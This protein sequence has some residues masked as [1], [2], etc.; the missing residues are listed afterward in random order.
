MSDSE[1]PKF[2]E[3]CMASLV[4]V[5]NRQEMETQTEDLPE[6][7]L[8]PGSS[9]DGEFNLSDEYQEDGLDHETHGDLQGDSVEALESGD[10]MEFEYEPAI[11]LSSLEFA[12]HAS[13]LSESQCIL[14]GLDY[15]T[16]LQLAAEL[17]KTLLE[18]NKELENSLKH[19]QA[20]IDDQA[21][22]IEYLNKQNIALREVNENQVKTCEQLEVSNSD[23][24]KTNRKLVDENHADKHNLKTLSFTVECLESRCEEL[25]RQLEQ[26]RNEELH[27]L[28]SV[29]HNH[30]N[31]TPNAIKNGRRRKDRRKSSSI[32]ECLLS[33]EKWKRTDSE[34]HLILP[35]F[36]RHANDDDRS[37]ATSSDD[38]NP[39][40][41]T[42]SES[43]GDEDDDD[44]EDEKEEQDGDE[45]ERQDHLGAEVSTGDI[46]DFFQPPSSSGYSSSS[47]DSHT[48]P[49]SSSEH[50]DNDHH[51][52]IS[53][54]AKEL[55]DATR[56][57]NDPH[58]S[59]PLTERD[60]SSLE[61]SHEHDL[62]LISELNNLR[63]K[64]D[65]V[66]ERAKELE[67]IISKLQVENAAL[68][69]SDL[70]GKANE[71][72]LNAIEDDGLFH[73]TLTNVRDEMEDLDVV[74]SGKVCRTCLGPIEDFPLGELVGQAAQQISQT[75]RAQDDLT[76]SATTTNAASPTD[77]LHCLQVPTINLNPQFPEEV[78]KVPS[79]L[80][81]RASSL[82]PFGTPTSNPPLSL[83]EEL[84]M[85]E[86]QHII[87]DP[88]CCFELDPDI[89]VT[90]TNAQTQ[91]DAREFL[92][93]LQEITARTEE[94]CRHQLLSLKERFPP[95]DKRELPIM[96]SSKTNYKEIFKEIFHVLS[97]AQDEH[98]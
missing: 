20:H 75:L 28:D 17:G 6:S 1:P 34:F 25:Q 47:I 8:D 94:S 43:N 98:E 45:E 30:T 64:Y 54:L 69:T 10:E 44:D 95:V 35:T 77:P 39:S 56:V 74:R 67:I 78:S 61:L 50:S 23:L 72:S 85:Y 88:D 16:D 22:E 21:Q 68:K 26:I 55:K 32:V 70:E 53:T 90:Q 33:S 41:L 29:H 73:H 31:A 84:L 76:L 24:E 66:L 71:E 11:S 87:E 38:P 81:I 2:C 59:L 97:Q 36:V 12:R 49:F 4:R 51:E 48:H 7:R 57:P 37:G 86:H 13:I 27:S 3:A 9:D 58:R 79:Q 19:Q 92:R 52:N 14:C 91:T 93:N 15:E 42:H 89:K 5:S 65:E 40:S 18:R 82:P 60:L 80:L 63:G 96:M 46:F 83:Q 62:Q